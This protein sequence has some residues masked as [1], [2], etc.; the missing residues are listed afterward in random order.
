MKHIKIYE[1]YTDEEIRGLVGDLQGIGH[2]KVDFDVSFEDIQ[3][4][5]STRRGY[6]TGGPLSPVRR[7][8]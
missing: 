7:F 1:D 3:K 8:F 4:L 6:Q 2:H 5:K